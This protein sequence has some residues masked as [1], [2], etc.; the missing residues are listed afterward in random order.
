[1]K[2]MF[3]LFLS[4]F[5]I[6]CA[7]HRNTS[8]EVIRYVEERTILATDFTSEERGELLSSAATTEGDMYFLYRKN[9]E[10]GQRYTVT[11]KGQNSDVEEEVALSLEASVPY[12]F[13]CVDENGNIMLADTATL[14]VYPVGEEDCT[15][16][17][18]VWAS[19]GLVPTNNNGIICQTYDQSAYFIYDCMTGDNRG[20]YLDRD[21]LFGQGTCNT[22]L[23]G[24]FGEEF[25]LASGGIYEHVG[26]EWVLR[27]PSA[28]TSMSHPGFMARQIVKDEEGVWRLYD[29]KQQYVYTPTVIKPED[30][31]QITL[32]ITVWQDRYTLKAALSQYQIDHPNVTIEYRFRCEELPEIKQEANSL[33]QMTNAELVSSNAADIYVLDYLP[34]ENFEEKGLLE[35][36]SELVRPYREDEA[37]FGDILAAYETDGELYAVPWFFSPRFIVCKKELVPFVQDIDALAAYLEEHPKEPGL[38]PY[39][40]RDRPEIFLAM[41]YDFYGKAL[42]GDV[43][44]GSVTEKEDKITP[45]GV[46]NF[47]HSAKVIYDREQENVDATVLPPSSRHSMGYAYLQQFPCDTDVELLLEQEEGSFVL[48]PYTPMGDSAILEI[49]YHPDL[50]IVPVDSVQP[51]FLFGIH[52][53]SQEKEAA[54]E[55]ISYLLSYFEN[56][57]RV[58]KS[59]EQF[60]WLPGIPIYKTALRENLMYRYEAGH[61]GSF[62]EDDISAKNHKPGQYTPDDVDRLM[63]LMD[64]FRTPG[65]SADAAC[66]DAYSILEERGVG[67]LTGEKTLEQTAE[68]VYRGLMLLYSEKQ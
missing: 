39:Y 16:S 63:E 42:Y 35:D 9:A 34:W 10:D 26:S 43:S 5:L 50:A 66:D 15:Q 29:A 64:S 18:A 3:L 59:I 7:D 30:E 19:G 14:Y 40:Y 27:V 49:Y 37:Y 58:D 53:G 1:M 46:E 28:K 55:L 61:S 68:D 22:F 48:L 54:G 8:D 32:R 12:L 24:D 31:E 52:S 13:I 65:L 11:K 38:I 17:F 67:Y 57:G 36:L 45:E 60:G 21:F 51:H 44:G 33:L 56:T 41:M 23:D 2:K 25:L 4:V 20:V 62:D 47:L 6:A